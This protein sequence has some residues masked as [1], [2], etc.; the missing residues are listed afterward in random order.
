MMLDR[1]TLDSLVLERALKVATLRR[2]LAQHAHRP[3]VVELLR[4]RLRALVHGNAVKEI[5]Q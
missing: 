1:Q 5:S 3:N 4:A 2:L